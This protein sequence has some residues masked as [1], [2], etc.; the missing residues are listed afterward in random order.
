MNVSQRHKLDSRLRLKSSREIALADVSQLFKLLPHHG[1]GSSPLDFSQ[2]LAEVDE[3]P[4][5]HHHARRLSLR[6]NFLKKFKGFT[7]GNPREE[8]KKKFLLYEDRC[9]ESNRNI[10]AYREGHKCDHLLQAVMLT[11]QRKISQVLGRFDFDELLRV[12]RWG[13]GSTSSCK[14][15]Q[16]SSAM[17]FASRPDVTSEFLYKARL[18]LPLLP[19][20]SA[21]LADQEYGF[22]GNPMMPVVKGNRITFVP[23][24]AKTDR[25][26]AVE[27]HVNVFFQNGLGRMI[28]R[29]LKTRAQID[30]DDQTLNQRLARQGSIDDGL[31]TLDL[32]GA[33]DTICRELVRDLLPEDWFSW[34]DSAR[35][36]WGTLDGEVIHYQKFSSMGN[37]ATFDLESL[38]F[39]ALSSAVVELTGYNSFWVNVFGDDIVV[40]S[41][42]ADEVIRIL[43]LVGFLVNRQKSFTQ[44]PFR[45]SCGLDY[46][47][48]FNVRSVYL[49]E[50]PVTPLD[51]IVIANQLRRLSHQWGDE[52]GCDA[53]LK[54]AYE[55]ALSR[56]PRDLHRYRVP[57]GFELKGSRTNGY[58]GVGI[59]SN[60]DEAVP[61]LINTE[62]DG[63]FGFKTAGFSARTVT[64]LSMDRSLA[65]AGTHTLSDQ[66]NELPLRDRTIYREVSVFV[67]GDWVDLGPWLKI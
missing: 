35:S 11:A 23:K 34:L 28:R 29:R 25:T 27:P 4:R 31:A 38:I 54:T 58:D 43:E 57:F 56:V 20:W 50:V 67:P 21:L 12:S 15:S 37:G 42:A 1:T 64:H 14:G 62:P 61:H 48:G 52:R 7:F 6:N 59:L 53:S 17:K 26:I 33:S 63:W 18:S 9:R 65:T 46:Y 55:F 32:E 13:P 16:V 2:A 45:E 66:G 49:K 30:L 41:G 40:P 10:R 60:L 36:H 19:S 39:W 47:L 22:I 3:K 44:G 5:D 8:A 51:W 24:T